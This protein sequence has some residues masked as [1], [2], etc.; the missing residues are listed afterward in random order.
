MTAPLQDATEPER[1]GGKAV[2]LGAAIR[3]GLPV[4]HGVALSVAFVDAI[5]AG[6]PGALARLRALHVELGGGAVA[7]RS[8]AVGEDGAAASF[9]GQHATCLNVISADA[10]VDAV[11]TVWDSGRTEH[12]RAY[13][14][15][16]GVTGEPRV[17][18]VVQRLVRA[19]IAG[20]LFTRDPVTGADERVVEASWGLGEAVVTGLVTPDSYRI[21]RSGRVVAHTAGT[22][23]VMIVQRDGGGTEEVAVDPGRAN[24]RALDDAQLRALHELATACETA[25]GGH[26]HDIEWAFAGDAL[27]LLQHRPITRSR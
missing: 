25:F 26:G 1:F 6:A 24:T 2:A 4:P 17:A 8:S 14:Q 3:A 15:R 10:L 27:H 19:D 9:A 22:K 18:V 23:D 13:R 11:R 16:L 5:V 12:A 20:V 21:D 7:A